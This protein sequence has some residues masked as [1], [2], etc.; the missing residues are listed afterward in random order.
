MLGLATLSLG[1]AVHNTAELKAAMADKSVAK[2]ELAAGV[3]RLTDEPGLCS[4][5]EDCCLSID[6]NL[7]VVAAAGAAV[8][9]DGGR[10]G[11]P[12]GG[13]TV[14]CT[15]PGVTAAL[16][17]LEITNG[18]GGIYNGGH[19]DPDHKY[20]TL[21]VANCSIHHNGPDP[22]FGAGGIGNAGI[23][24]VH[25]SSIHDNNASV[26]GGGIYSLGGHVSISSSSISYNGAMNYGFGGGIANWAGTTM[27]VSDSTIE[28]N[29][30]DHGA[31]I[32]NDGD[33]T[34]IKSKIDHNTAR[35]LGGGILNVDS[36]KK[37]PLK[38][39]DTTISDNKP[40]E[41]VLMDGSKCKY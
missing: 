24:A 23:L 40:D 19:P 31:G 18:A 17:G 34:V 20:A 41:C 27:V 14:F 39:T 11:D 5:P 7:D 9:L 37:D 4:G 15:S 12:H 35:Q 3:Y 10:N 2:I 25:G 6:R 8:V 32:A 29:T 16:R 26:S 33:L 28:Y 38:L 1:A 22:E 13:Q 30:A 21:T 36:L